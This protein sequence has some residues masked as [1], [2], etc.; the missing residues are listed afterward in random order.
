M[1]LSSSTYP[2]WLPISSKEV[3]GVLT[4]VA[5]C[6]IYFSPGKVC[7]QDDVFSNK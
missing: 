3:G 1:F 4:P 2:W 5:G 7:H 6:H